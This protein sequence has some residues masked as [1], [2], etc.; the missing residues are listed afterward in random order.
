MTYRMNI[1]SE[2]TIEVLNNETRKSIIITVGQK[3]IYEMSKP[4]TTKDRKNNGRIVEVLGFSD[5]LMGDVIVRYMDTKRRGIKHPCQSPRAWVILVENSMTVED[6]FIW[7]LIKLELLA[8]N[9]SMIL[10]FILLKQHPCQSPCVCTLTVPGTI[11]LSY[12]LID[13]S[14]VTAI[15]F[16]GG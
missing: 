14:M 12:F 8:L 2:E 5:N 4:T 13:I 9:C 10:W 15:T 3:Y 16:V 1:I 6:D 11:E 7:L